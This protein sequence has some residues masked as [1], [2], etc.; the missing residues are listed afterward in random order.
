MSTPTRRWMW[1]FGLLLVVSVVTMSLAPKRALADHL[2]SHPGAE[3]IYGRNADCGY[4]LNNSTLGDVPYSSTGVGLLTGI[5]DQFG[6]TAFLGSNDINSFVATMRFHLQNC[7]PAP[8]A[9]SNQRRNAAAF[10]I[11]TM[12]GAPAGTPANEPCV[13]GSPYS[14]DRWEMLVRQYDAAGL[15]SYN[16]DAWF[17]RNT[18]VQPPTQDVAWYATS[19][20]IS[21]SI[22]VRAPNGWALYVIKR[23]CGNPLSIPGVLTPLTGPFTV[24]PFAQKPTL[25][26][27][28]NP[29]A[30]DFKA[31]I[32][33]NRRA[34]PITVGRQYFLRRGGSDL[35]PFASFTSS[36]TFDPTTY[37]FNY[38]HTGAIPGLQPGDLVCQ[39]ITVSPGA[40][41]SDPTGGIATISDPSNSAEDCAQVLRKPYSKVY[42]GD[43]MVGAGFGLGCP[44]DGDAGVVGFNRGSGPFTGSGAQ[45]AIFA[46]GQIMDFADSQIITPLN[47]KALSFA[48][49]GGGYAGGLY[50]GDLSNAHAVCAPDY[51][52]EAVTPLT[53]DVVITGRNVSP[54]ERDTIYV[55]GN[56][57]ITGDIKYVGAYA[58]AA[59]VPSFRL[60]VRGNI[61]VAPGV[62][63]LNGL[64]VAQPQI[65]NA[66]SG[67]F[68]S[69]SDKAWVA[70]YVPVFSTTN[71]VTACANP[72]KVSGAVAADVIKLTRTRGTLSQAANSERYNTVY[73]AGQ[74]P[75]ETFI[76]SPLVWLDG[77]LSP[78]DGSYDT[79]NIL[80]PI[81]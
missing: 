4:F 39:R 27:T 55:D 8:D 58:N 63:E 31:S 62:T 48:N 42:G 37:D 71:L 81:L 54:G 35:P 51:F 56:A 57:F 1:G 11:L 22:I 68:Y 59:Q 50:G 66:A 26:P 74:G 34:G 77:S 24:T 52:A 21:P 40:G 76:Y 29:T 60:I 19:F 61:H 46:L 47:P 32:E 20:S 23:D 6:N 17:D 69:C 80:P 14:V 73:P 33:L 15:I 25:T 45:L 49:S 18:R 64:Y 10:M 36:G 3:Q 2:C 78:T 79:Y 9:T 53:G 16:E 44:V 75:A 41:E 30:V 70:G 38:P 72:L 12:Q 28:D 7:T 5:P 43:V 67:R 65:G 13:P